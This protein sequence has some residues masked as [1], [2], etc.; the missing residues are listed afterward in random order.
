MT[1][2]PILLSVILATACGGSEATR[3]QNVMRSVRGYNDAMR[4]QRLPSAAGFISVVEREEFLD[5]QESLVE[6]LRIDDYEITRMR[7]LSK[8]RALVQVRFTWHMDNV[9]VVET[10]TT[11]QSWERHGKSWLLAEEHRVRGE[12]MPG[13]AEKPDEGELEEIETIPPGSEEGDGEDG[14]DAEDGE[15]RQIVGD[16]EEPT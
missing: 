16:S 9:G 1:R 8:N 15:M 6:N 12:S 11:K 4:W 13:V 2:T 10:T 14:E 7:Y 3:S 5:E